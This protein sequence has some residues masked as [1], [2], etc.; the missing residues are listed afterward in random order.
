MVLIKAL[1]T[2]LLGR[3]ALYNEKE[4]MVNRGVILVG[5]FWQ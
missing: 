4:R 3:L 1:L 2:G 5:A